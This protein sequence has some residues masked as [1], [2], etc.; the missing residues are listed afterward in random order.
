[1]P[2]RK[3]LDPPPPPYGPLTLPSRH[4]DVA[5]TKIPHFIYGTAWK[6]DRSTTLVTQALTAGF[7][8][9]DTAAQPKHYQEGLVGDAIR[10]SLSNGNLSRSDLYIQ[11]KFTSPSGQDRRNMPYDP[12]ANLAKQVRDSV[13]S[14]LLHLATSTSHEE[15]GEQPYIDAL[16]LH[17]PLPTLTETISAWR[18]LET[19][20]P[21]RIHHLGISN[22]DLLTLQALFDS[23]EVT[24]KPSVVQNRFY[25]ETGWDTSLRRF[26]REKGVIY[27]CFWTLTGNPSLLKSEVVTKVSEALRVSNW[28]QDVSK[29]VALYVLVMGLDGL[30]VLN[31]TTDEGR[32]RSDLAGLAVWKSWVGSRHGECERRWKRWMAELKGL[33]GEGDEG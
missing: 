10:T 7:R 8:G 27:Q 16:I 23:E 30:C 29:E 12:S 25:G 26:C 32:M 13:E 21:T 20:V 22:T 33:I 2:F 18:V 3:P 14:S 15:T 4:T 24:I 9:I 19:Y 31:G 17:S 1:M 11:T 5:P 6:K 28:G